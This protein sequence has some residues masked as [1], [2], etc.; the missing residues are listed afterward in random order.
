MG[1]GRRGAKR[2]AGSWNDDASPD[3]E[4][5]AASGRTA[6]QIAKEEGR[7]ECVRAFKEHTKAADAEAKAAADAAGEAAGEKPAETTE[8]S[9]S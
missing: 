4:L 3:T 1:K 2:K 7:T 5:R 6:L 9:D 8:G